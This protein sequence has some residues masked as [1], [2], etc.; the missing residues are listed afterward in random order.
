M[1]MTS[2]DAQLT[3]FFV[4]FFFK[5]HHHVCVARGGGGGRGDGVVYTDVPE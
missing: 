5:M 1:R 3:V 4:G 2:I